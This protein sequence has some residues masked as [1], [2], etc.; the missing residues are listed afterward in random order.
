MVKTFIRP[1]EAAVR[2]LPGGRGAA[3]KLGMV[4]WRRTV[5]VGEGHLTNFPLPPVERFAT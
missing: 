1:L 3:L 4:Y 2:R 5:E